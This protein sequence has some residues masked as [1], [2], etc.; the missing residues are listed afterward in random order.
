MCG[1]FDT[2]LVTGDNPACRPW[3][4][5]RVDQELQRLFQD[6]GKAVFDAISESSDIGET[7]SRLREEGYSLTMQLN[8]QKETPTGTEPP[9]NGLSASK[10]P[11]PTFRIDGQDLSFLQ[12]IGIDPT[13]RRPRRR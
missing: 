3:G 7:V 11:D 8:C 9:E 5:N 12:S 6:L 2:P 13:R 4:V 10:G 1:S